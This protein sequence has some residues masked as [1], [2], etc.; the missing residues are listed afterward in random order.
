MELSRGKL[1]IVGFGRRGV[2]RIDDG[3]KTLTRGVCISR[4]TVLIPMLAVHIPE[5][6]VD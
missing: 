2:I 1:H 6:G 3:E 5:W 4:S